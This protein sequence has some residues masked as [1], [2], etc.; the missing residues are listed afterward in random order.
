MKQMKIGV[1]IPT[2]KAESTIISVLSVI[3]DCVSSVYV[4]DDKCP[5]ESGNIVSTL[6][7]DKRVKV[8]FHKENEGVGGAVKTGYAAGF[9]EGCDIMVKIDSDGQMDPA[10]V[11]NLVAAIE[12]G[13][14]DY[15]KGNRFFNPDD[16]KA[17]P[18][19]RVFGNLG[20]SF[21]TKLSTGYWQ[22]FDPTNG[23]TAL[24]SQAYNK[25]QIG[26]VSQRYFFETDMLFRLN[27][28]GAVVVDMPMKAVY[29]GEHSSLS[30]TKSLFEFAFR[31]MR[32]LTKRIVYQYFIR[33]FSPGSLNLLIGIPLM[34]FALIFGISSWIKSITSAVPATAGTAVLVAL[35][36]IVSMQ[37]LQSFLIHDYN[38]IPRSPLQ[39]L[40]RYEKKDD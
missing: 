17:M 15:V 3:P 11:P 22:I 4:V 30:V 14:A 35:C 13:I 24:H 1:V 38:V 20:L 12:N 2:Y 23:F 32:I 31:H 28:C 40:L 27:L 39:K 5:N 7:K 34:L 36:F 10:L 16:V 6:C 18:P 33:D 8:L 9:N 29:A 25:L 21:L 26:K 19:K 37:L